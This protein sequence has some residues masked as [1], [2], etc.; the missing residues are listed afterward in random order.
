MA[1]I[2]PFPSSDNSRTL[3][4]LNVS[5]HRFG[6]AS[7][8]GSKARDGRGPSLQLLHEPNSFRGE[9][10]HHVQRVIESDGNLCLNALSSV[11]L[12]RPR[13]CPLRVSFESV[14]VDFQLHMG[15]LFSRSSRSSCKKRFS[16]FS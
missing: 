2:D 15:S 9:H 1:W 14:R 6:V 12:A 3:Q 7:K 5:A 16:T 8:S 11:E 13:D 4:F 10:L